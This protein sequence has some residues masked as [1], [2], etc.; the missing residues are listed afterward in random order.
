MSLPTMH[1][2][3]FKSPPLPLFNLQGEVNTKRWELSAISWGDLRDKTSAWNHT[4]P[5]NG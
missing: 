4:P 2:R 5:F 1:R 3:A